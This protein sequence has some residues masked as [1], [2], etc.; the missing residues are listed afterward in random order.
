MLKRQGQFR[1]QLLVQAADRKPLHHML[2]F[3]TSIL[4]TSKLGKKAR[5]SLDVDPIEMF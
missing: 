4:E 2:T 5:W 1:Y 3:L